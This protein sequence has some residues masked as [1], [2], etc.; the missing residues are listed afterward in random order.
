MKW[1]DDSPAAVENNAGSASSVPSQQPSENVYDTY[2]ANLKRPAV[3]ANHTSGPP[4]LDKQEV[5]DD[6]WA[7]NE[8]QPAKESDADQKAI[9]MMDSS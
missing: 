9:N 7:E 8:P 2:L 5:D 3:P 4:K 1:G 6:I